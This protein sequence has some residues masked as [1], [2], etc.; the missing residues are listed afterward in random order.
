LRAAGGAFRSAGFG[1]AF[2]AGLGAATGGARRAPLAGRREVFD[3]AV[4]WVFFEG[5]MAS[6]RERCAGPEGGI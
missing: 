6:L 4:F 5:A 1:A 2:G 3:F